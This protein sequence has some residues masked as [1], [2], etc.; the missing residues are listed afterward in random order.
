MKRSSRM[1]VVGVVVLAAGWGCANETGGRGDATPADGSADVGADAVPSDTG[2]ETSESCSPDLE[3]RTRCSDGQLA[4]CIA[5]LWQRANC[6]G[7]TVCDDGACLPAL[8][9]PGDASCTDDRT[10]RVCNTTGT[11]YLDAPCVDSVCQDGACVAGCV[12]GERRC[13]AED[14][15][16]CQADLSEAVV[17]TCDTAQGE[18]CRGGRCLT[19]CEVIGT[20]RGYVGCDYWAADLPNDASAT[21]NIFAFAFSNVSPTAEAAVT[22]TYPWGTVEHVTVP[23]GDLA[24]HK[25]PVPRW[26]S[27]ITAAGIGRFGFRIE[28]DKPI[29]AWMFNPLERYDADAEST[30]ATND[31]SILIPAP[32]L[33]TSYVAVT[34][35]DPGEFSGPPYVTVI[36]TRDG[37]KVTVTPTETIPIAQSPYLLVKGAAATVTLNAYETLN[38]EPPALPKVRT[39][40]TGTRIE[41]DTNAVA[42]FSGNRCARVPDIGRFCD[43]IETQLPPLEAWGDSFVVAKFTDRGGEFDYFR[44]VAQEDGTVLTFD[45]P[46]A[47]GPEAPTLQAGAFWQF[48]SKSDFALTSNHPILL[49]Q[50]MASES[51]TTPPGPFGVSEDC[52]PEIGGTCQGDPALVLP[53]P[54]AQ[55]R[56]DQI[57]LVPDTYAH[58]FISV[59]F[60]AGTT[61]T[62]DGVAVDTSL[63]RTIGSAAWRAVT[64]PTSGGRRTLVGSAPLGVIVYG[65]DHNISYAYNG[66]LDFRNLRLPPPP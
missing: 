23:A 56:P 14:V 10:R 30:V 57:F 6:P 29:A 55:W 15:L 17:A 5:G 39:D 20:K 8:C 34:W 59:V 28:S 44:V 61:M 11:R 1:A 18:L 53:A 26:L 64:L 12:P 31:A 25:L 2:A 37:T 50:F 47:S 65:F 16:E 24:T 43:H 51:M 7:A 35:S 38:L 66:G 21:D 36:A 19:A 9:T 54:V 42:V 3:G 40:M 41:A 22:V 63:A 45:P 4:S 52:P 32:S 62:L 48:A 58:Q 27:Q 33:G 46:L 13:A 49:A 60:T